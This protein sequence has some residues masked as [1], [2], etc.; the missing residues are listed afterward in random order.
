MITRSFHRLRGSLRDRKLHAICALAFVV[1]VFLGVRAFPGW[2]QDRLVRKA[3]EY[4]ARGDVRGAFLS[5]HEA[6]NRD[7]ACAPAVEFMAQLSLRSQAADEIFWR[8][9]LVALQPRNATR[10]VELA[11]AALRNGE[12]FT[13]RHALEGIALADQSFGYYAAAATLALSTGQLWLAQ[14]HLEEAHRLQP[15]DG[16]I[17]LMLARVRLTSP[18]PETRARAHRE[19]EGFTAEFALRR[20]A[21]LALLAE[22]RAQGKFD[23]AIRVAQQLRDLPEAALS[24]RLNYLEELDRP[25]DPSPVE[26]LRPLKF[27]NELAR[28]ESESSLDES[29]IFAVASWLTSHHHSDKT[30][31]WLGMLPEARRETPLGR[32]ADAEAIACSEDWAALE[33]RASAGDWGRLEY[34]RFAYSARAKLAGTGLRGTPF[35]TAWQNARQA[36][37]TDRD[38]VRTLAGLAERWDWNAEADSLWWELASDANAP[39]SA[40]QHLYALNRKRGATDEMLRISEHIL[41]LDPDDPIARNNV[42]QLSLLLGRLSPEIE[43]LASENAALHPA[44][45]AL[46]STYAFSLH[47]QGRDREAIGHLLALPGQPQSDPQ[48]AAY[49]GI[50]YSA[51]GQPERARPLLAL[52]AGADLLPEEAQL[53]RDA[54]KP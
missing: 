51:T 47:L 17:R 43:R 26:D 34:L 39:L 10:R 8:R 18:D 23:V 21:C 29:S 27:E 31:K 9:R 48:I 37:G 11:E 16:Q 50:L 33:K 40:L 7:A 38:K 19:M 5:A 22:A 49:F 14:E 54:L 36:A 44:D 15:G 53:V 42:A 3:G 12:T 41:R 1:S 6:L 28:L 30:R 25:R 52:A 45:W 2:W 20:E 4:L 32:L 13:A 46:N 35:S 24:D